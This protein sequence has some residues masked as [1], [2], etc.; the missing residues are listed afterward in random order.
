M[1]FGFVKQSGGHVTVYSEPGHGTAFRLYLPRSKAHVTAAVITESSELVGGTEKVLV[2]E[3]NA[4]LRRAVVDQL[5]SLGY[6]VIETDSG[7]AA[8]GVLRDDSGI[9]LL[10]TDII[11]PGDLN[12]LDLAETATIERPG[13]KVLLTS[14]FPGTRGEQRIAGAPAHRMLHKP[15]RYKDLAR[16][17][18]EALDGD[19]PAPV[20]AARWTS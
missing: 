9:D 1:V 13:L 15:Y 3:D 8:I 16:A 18:R 12:G 4:Q 6:H 2:V 10:F 7:D 14:G 11:M 17:I 20:D 19:A 5:V